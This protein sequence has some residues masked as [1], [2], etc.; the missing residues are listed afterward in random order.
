[1]FKNFQ[2]STVFWILIV[3]SLLWLGGCSSDKKI[4]PGERSHFLQTPTAL[5]RDIDADDIKIIIADPITN[6]DWTQVG[7]NA[8]HAIPHVHVGALNRILWKRDIGVGSSKDQ[9]ILSGPVVADGMVYTMD[10]KGFVAATDA[11][12][13]AK[14]WSKDTSTKDKKYYYHGGGVSYD[15]GRVYVSTLTGEIWALDGKTG[16]VVWTFDVN[17]PLRTA[18]TVH[19]NRLM[20]ITTNNR[21]ITLDART[22][23]KIWHHDDTQDAL[24]FM[25]GGNPTAAS[26]V[27]AI[28]PYSSGNVF[29][30]RAD[31]GT[32]LWQDTLTSSES[33]SSVSMIA[34][35]RAR[36]IVDNY[37]VFLASQNGHMMAINF[38]NGERLWEKNI[39]CIRTPAIGENVLFTITT[40]SHMVCLTKDKGKILW[41]SEL[42]KYQNPDK[43]KDPITW[44]GPV[45]AGNRLLI[46][47]TN[48]Q[49]LS[50]SPATGKTL[51]TFN[52]GAPILLS[53]V[54]ANE[55][56]Y[57]LQDNGTLLAIQ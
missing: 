46:T 53:P 41:I 13:G 40:S 50:L 56:V 4:L 35:I 27:E 14:I 2:T 3:T 25:G 23:E 47:G 8:M 49:L 6:S 42:P 11:M 15:N 9:F 31:N 44:A 21:T 16:S 22:G 18:P 51:D 45:L 1:M 36:P 57:I 29:A 37:T 26:E 7:G 34:Q 5:K 20:V 32:V 30:L 54:V 55:L 33:H 38:L 43:K 28:I 17:R 10:A 19:E 48:G 39:G 52:T 24:G 12:T